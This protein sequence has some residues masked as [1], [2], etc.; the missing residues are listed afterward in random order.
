MTFGAFTRSSL[1]AFGFL[2]CTHAIAGFG[3]MGNVDG[4]SG[5][6]IGGPALI[7]ILAGAAIGYFAERAIN[8]SKLDRMGGRY[9]SEYLGGKTG[10]IVGAI[11]LP[12][13]I[14]LLR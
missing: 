1:V 14:G 6:T 2:A 3:G 4:D 8:K 13:L 12:V 9:S 10:A 5:G 11:A 7:A